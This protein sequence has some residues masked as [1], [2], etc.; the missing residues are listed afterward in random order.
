MLLLSGVTRITGNECRHCE[1]T[2]EDA[3][4]HPLRTGEV[5][6]SRDEVMSDTITFGDCYRII[7]EQ[8]LPVHGSSTPEKPDCR[9]DLLALLDKEFGIGWKETDEAQSLPIVWDAEG[10]PWNGGMPAIAIS[11]V[12]HYGGVIDP[13]AEHLEYT[14]AKSE[15]KVW[16]AR[17]T[18]LGDATMT[19]KQRFVD[20]FRDLLLLRWPQ[21][22][23]RTTSWTKLRALGLVVPCYD[24]DDL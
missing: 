19:M 17:Q 14:F 21:A 22:A 10:N 12:R 24:P 5:T 1:Q 4:S 7:L 15:M 2:R 11:L 16:K 9:R 20:L 3:K 6:R 8:G 13:F 18:G 23:D